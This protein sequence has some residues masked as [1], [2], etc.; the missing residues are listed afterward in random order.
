MAAVA[1]ATLDT[2]VLLVVNIEVYDDREMYDVDELLHDV[3]DEQ[4]NVDAQQVIHVLSVNND[5]VMQLQVI[6]LQST[7]DDVN[8]HVYCV[9]VHVLMDDVDEQNDANEQLNGAP[10]R[11]MQLQQDAYDVTVLTV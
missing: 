6:M 11:R 10:Q 3:N 5:S 9:H 2:V 1:R 7:Q 4:Q 8:V